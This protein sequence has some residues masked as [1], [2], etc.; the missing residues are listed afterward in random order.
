MDNKKPAVPYGWAF[1]FD[2]GL[3]GLNDY[4]LNADLGGLLGLLGC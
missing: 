2:R 1:V 3:R 4:Y